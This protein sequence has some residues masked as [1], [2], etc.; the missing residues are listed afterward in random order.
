[1][2][3]QGLNGTQK[4]G[5]NAKLLRVICKVYLDAR[6]EKKLLKTQEK[7][8]EV[9]ERILYA[10]ADIGIES[11]VDKATG[12]EA[13]KL[14]TKHKLELFLKQFMR[15]DAAQLV[16][17][18][19]D[20]FFEMIYRMRGWTWNYTHKHPGV[21]G[22]W[23]NDIVYERVAPLVLA[24]LKKKNPITEKGVRAKKH[25]QY[26]SD[27]I[28]IPKL[29]NHLAA[30][31]ALGR[32]SNYDWNKFMVMLDTAF[33]KQYQQLKMLLEFPDEEVKQIEEKKNYS[34]F[35]KNLMQALNYSPKE[36]KK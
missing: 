7:T 8:A 25:H 19:E 27:E 9:A 3:Y 30:V 16:K 36:D 33:P 35:D 4:T 26:L 23:I 14:K 17:R 1:V 29:L 12:F 6:K 34:E 21:V 20:S 13:E 22:V 24:E 15:E 18:F 28:G 2:Q 10:L 5:Y 31:E 11:L 32:A